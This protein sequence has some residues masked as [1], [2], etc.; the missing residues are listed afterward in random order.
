MK[1]T[2]QLKEDHQG[3]KLALSI[4]EKINLKLKKGENVNLK[5]LEQLLEFIRVFVYKCHHGKEED[6]LF[7]AMEKAGVPNEGGPISMM[8]EEHNLGR[9][10]VKNFAKAIEEYKIGDPRAAKQIIKNTNGYITLLKEHIDKED[11]ILYMIADAHLSV[12]TQKDLLEKF[13]IIENEKVGRGKH[14]EF[15]K[16]LNNLQKIY[17][18]K[19]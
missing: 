3:V 16:M 4:L 18:C 12:K 7:P 11:N 2:E 19:E 6:L 9:N 8:L 13:E 17:L 14:E 10:Y 5:H 1:A 15:H